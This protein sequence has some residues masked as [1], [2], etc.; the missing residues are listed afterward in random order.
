MKLIIKNNNSN[1]NNIE[2][3][4]ISMQVTTNNFLYSLFKNHQDIVLNLIKSKIEII[5]KENLPVV[6]FNNI[7]GILFLKN[8]VIEIIVY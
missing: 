6:L 1:S 5:D 8:N 3:N 4:F 2:Y 7:N